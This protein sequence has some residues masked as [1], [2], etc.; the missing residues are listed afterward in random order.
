MDFVRLAKRTE[1]QDRRVAK[2]IDDADRVGIMPWND[3]LHVARTGGRKTV[4]RPFGYL[5]FGA[6]L[7]EMRVSAWH[8]H[9]ARKHRPLTAICARTGALGEY[10]C[11]MASAL[12]DLLHFVFKRNP[13][14]RPQQM[15]RVA[16]RA[17]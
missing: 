16:Y 12:E 7:Y 13:K 9:A 2:L 5:S 3:R 6:V 4:D 14:H 11:K 8:S 10:E 1:A 15:G 17:G